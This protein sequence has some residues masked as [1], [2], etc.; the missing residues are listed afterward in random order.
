MEKIIELTML[1]LQNSKKKLDLFKSAL[2]CKKDLKYQFIWTLYENV[3]LQKNTSSPAVQLKSEEVL[4][5][6]RKP[7]SRY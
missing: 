7:A 5:K 6:L 4:V 1:N 2:S 3:F